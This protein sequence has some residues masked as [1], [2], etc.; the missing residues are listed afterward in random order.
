MA[1]NLE[2]EIRRQ[3]QQMHMTVYAQCIS[4]NG[5]YL[6]AGNSYGTIAIFSITASL[7]AEANKETWKPLVSFK[8]YDGAIYAL[9]STEKF[10]ISAG[11]GDI[12]GWAWADIFQKN[13]KIAWSLSLPVSSNF[14]AFETNA[15]AYSTKDNI[16]YSGGG[17]SVVYAWDLESGTKKETFAGHTDY[18]HCVSLY[19]QSQQLASSAEDGS[20]RIWDSR[21]SG[22]AVHL[23]EPYKHEECA[24]PQHGKWVGCVSLDP[25]EEW[26]VCGGGPSLSLWHLR[27]LTPTVTFDAP[28]CCSQVVTFHE[29]SIIS[30]GSTPF[31]YHWNINGVPKTKVPCTA[32]SVFSLA[33]NTENGSNKVLCV[34]G[35]SSLID[36]YTNFG[37]RAFSL[38]FC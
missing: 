30:G 26:L 9:V 29:D 28:N 12:K 17:D 15:L 23:I 13:P 34:S 11:C 38:D 20:V 22:E 10:L 8:A 32:T 35:N 27:S 4:P 1:L 3:R 7:S 14:S 36:V 24:R 16:L 6:V 21:R 37:Y 33:I 31:V 19:H 18:I 2:Q 25:G 5:K